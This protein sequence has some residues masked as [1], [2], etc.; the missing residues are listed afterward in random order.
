LN[1]NTV[2]YNDCSYYYSYSYCYYDRRGLLSDYD[3]GFM[4]NTADV[5]KDMF[6]SLPSLTHL[7]LSELNSWKFPPGMLSIPSLKKL[8]L[9]DNYLTQVPAD[10]KTLVN[11]E[12]LHMRNNYNREEDKGIELES[13]SFRGLIKLRAL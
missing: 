1:D 3:V 5:A 7:D 8:F 10:V 9:R 2:S 12:E 13:T 11:L 4:G 6:K